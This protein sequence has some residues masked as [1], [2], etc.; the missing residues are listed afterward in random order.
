MSLFF[1][2]IPW[3][4]IGCGDS[5]RRLHSDMRLDNVGVFL[6]RSVRMYLIIKTEAHRERTTE[7]EIV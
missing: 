6:L 2:F 7:A 3:G 1:T 5:G 4:A